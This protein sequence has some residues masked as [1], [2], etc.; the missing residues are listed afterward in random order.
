[1]IA[2]PGVGGEGTQGILGLD[3]GACDRH[4]IP[5]VHDDGREAVV[6]KVLGEPGGAALLHDLGPLL[7]AAAV[8]D[9]DRDGEA[10]ILR[11]PPARRPVAAALL[12]ERAVA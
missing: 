1:R 11:A 3:D 6:A 4:G 8:E 5:A 9:H 10:A 2:A 7:D 12:L